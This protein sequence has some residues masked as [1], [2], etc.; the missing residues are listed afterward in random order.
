[1]PRFPFY[2]THGSAP[3]SYTGLDLSGTQSGGGAAAGRVSGGVRRAGAAAAGPS[4]RLIADADRGDPFPS[5]SGQSV[6]AKDVGAK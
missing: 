1:M 4:I 6:H 3:A 5:G 2:V